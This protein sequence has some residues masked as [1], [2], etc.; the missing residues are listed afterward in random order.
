MN[1]RSKIISLVMELTDKPK[2]D[3][4]LLLVT[5][6]EMEKNVG[7]VMICNYDQRNSNRMDF[8]RLQ[9]EELRS[10]DPRNVN[11]SAIGL[12]YTNY[13]LFWAQLKVYFLT[14][15][16]LLPIRVVNFLIANPILIS[17]MVNK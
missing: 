5:K 14:T 12:L 10:E 7:E 1:L 16:Q 2:P 6:R 4:M 8:L 17:A 11:Q 3:P 9:R 13:Y 15:L